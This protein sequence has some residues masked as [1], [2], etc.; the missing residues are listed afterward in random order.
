MTDYLLDTN[1]ASPLITLG[2]PLRARVLKAQQSGDTFA[3]TTVNLAE[4]WY[5]ISLL[6][7]AA[8]NQTEW[9]RL[10]PAFH[11]Y[12]IEERDAID[13]AEIQLALRRQGRQMGTIDALL[14]AVTLRYGLTLLTSDSDFAELPGLSQANWL[15]D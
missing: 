14:A 7:R 11:L 9:Q 8:Q 6:P 13:G 15:A 12:Q 2:H 10:R 4:L 3:L 1:H 5:G